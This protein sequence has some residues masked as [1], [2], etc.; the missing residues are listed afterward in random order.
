[1]S[2]RFSPLSDRGSMIHRLLKRS[3]PVILVLAVIGSLFPALPAAIAQDAAG[4]PTPTI[5]EEL[6]ALRGERSKIFLNSDGSRTGRFFTS[7]VHY[8]TQNGSWAEIDTT[9]VPSARAGYAWRNTAGSFEVH[10][11]PTADEDEMVSV[12]DASSSVTFG[13]A[14][15]DPGST[16]V[17]DGSKITYPDVKPGMDLVYE[18][19]EGEVKEFLVLDQAPQQP[20]DLRFPLALSNLDAQEAA[21]GA[22]DLVTSSGEIG[23]YIS[24]LWMKDSGGDAAAGEPGFSED[25][26]ASLSGPASSLTLTVTPDQAWLTAPERVYPVTID[27]TI[28]KETTD[29]T[30]VQ[31]N[32]CCT[33]VSAENEMKSGTYDG[34]GTKARSLLKFADVQT[35]IP[36][37]A[38]ITGARMY[39]WES[40]SYSCTPRDVSAHRITDSWDGNA[41]RWS[42]QPGVAAA[43]TTVNVAKGYSSSCGA[44]WVEF[45]NLG[46]MVDYWKTV[47]N[48]YGIEIRSPNET[49]NDW[50]KKWYAIGSGNRP[51]LEVFY[52][53]PDTTGPSISSISSSTHGI[54]GAWYPSTNASFSWLASDP[55]GIA[56]YSFVRDQT[57]NTTPPNSLQTTGTSTTFSNL[58][59]G[60][61]YFHVRAKDNA[62]NWGNPMHYT[63]R[64]DTGAPTDPSISS[65]SH[66]RDACSSNP[67]ATFSWASS[68]A[69]S[70]VEGYGYV[71][72]QSS[73]TVP[74]TAGVSSST[75][76]SFSVEF[77]RFHGHF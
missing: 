53:E 47:G 52:S 34:G 65:S 17:V 13:F 69:T 9:L 46:G 18:V 38:T 50:W 19:R 45:P 26:A 7:P 24:D 76:G 71:F 22:V 5:V 62:G 14:G 63:F 10:F 6:E 16:A 21:S 20:L 3:M 15:A 41:V 70:G 75:G 57:W 68:D 40:H 37:G 23:F 54:E 36:N 74:G 59:Q 51:Y 60:T 44:G 2:A 72:D 48:N 11:S 4:D 77:P 58:G 43:A 67:N 25:V 32:I 35:Q 31:S 64:V 73:S 55:S 33:D 39:V 1:M 29:D 56:G 27:P 49:T 8:Q 66:T 30:Y 28:T 61:H 12:T 42:T